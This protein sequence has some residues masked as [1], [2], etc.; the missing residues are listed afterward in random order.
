MLTV[1]IA[2]PPSTYTSFLSFFA[3]SILEKLYSLLF[4]VESNRFLVL[5]KFLSCCYSCFVLLLPEGVSVLLLLP[6]GVNVLLLP[7]GASC[8]CR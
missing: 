6:E 2:R 8:C 5:L 1:A 4:H 7:K 3:F